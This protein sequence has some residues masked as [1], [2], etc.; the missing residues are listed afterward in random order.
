MASSML[1]CFAQTGSIVFA[2]MFDELYGLKSSEA[3]T[4]G[5]TIVAP[6]VI[7]RFEGIPVAFIGGVT[8]TTP[9]LVMPSGIKGLRFRFKGRVF[10]VPTDK[11]SVLE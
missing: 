5:R 1:D 3:M 11:I 6:Y 9:Q 10:S 8:K 7:K 4:G 2:M